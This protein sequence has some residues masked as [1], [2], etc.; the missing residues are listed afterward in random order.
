M[1]H[2]SFSNLTYEL[3]S[4]LCVSAVCPGTQNGLSSTGSQ[5]NQYNLNKDRYNGCEIVMGNLEITQIESNWDFSFLKVK[6]LASL[7]LPINS[8]VVKWACLFLLVLFP[9]PDHPRGDRVC[10]H[11]YESLSGHSSLAAASHQRKQ[12]LRE[13]IRPLHLLQLS[14]GWLQW[15]EPARP[16]ESNR[17]RG[18]RGV[19]GPSLVSFCAC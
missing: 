19:L 3:Y 2:F 10:P 13:A 5:E 6:K 12:P 9:P 1:S 18:W 17:Y 14:Q 8:S 7:I 4:S 15:P 11:R 16:H